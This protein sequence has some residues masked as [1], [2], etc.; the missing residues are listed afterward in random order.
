MITCE[1]RDLMDI[2]QMCYNIATHVVAY[3]V[4][5]DY[6]VYV[7]YYCHEHVLEFTKDK[8][9]DYNRIRSLPEEDHKFDSLEWI[10]TSEGDTIEQIEERTV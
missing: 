6:T 7:K 9:S 4:S 3:T 1:K 5:G 2:N 8:V 10:Y